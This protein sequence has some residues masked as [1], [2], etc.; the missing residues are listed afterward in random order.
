M[1]RINNRVSFLPVLT[2]R[3]RR[4]IVQPSQR[5][6]EQQAQKEGGI[7]NNTEILPFVVRFAR[8]AEAS[9]P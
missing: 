9:N 7:L 4:D 3:K 6:T 5:K 1:I 2:N 8:P